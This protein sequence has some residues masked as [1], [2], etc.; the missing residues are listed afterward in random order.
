MARHHKSKC[1]IASIRHAPDAADQ[2]TVTQLMGDR[3][4]Y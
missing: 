3:S 1:T 4:L 2:M